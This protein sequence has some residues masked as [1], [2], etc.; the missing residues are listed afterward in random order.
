MESRTASSSAVV[1][2]PGAAEVVWAW[3]GTVSNALTAKASHEMLEMH[4]EPEINITVLGHNSNTAG[5][6]YDYESADAC[7][8]DGDGY[9]IEGLQVSD[10][11]YP[12]WFESSSK[13]GTQFDH[14]QLIKKPFEL[15]PGGYIGHFDVG[16]GSGWQQLTARHS[17]PS[18][19]ARA[20]GGGR[21]EAARTPTGGRAWG[22]AAQALR[23]GLG[24]WRWRPR[25]V[26]GVK[27]AVRRRGS[28]PEPGPHGGEPR[29]P[30]T[31]AWM[32]LAKLESSAPNATATIFALGVVGEVCTVTPW[33]DGPWEDITRNGRAT[34]LAPRDL[35]RSP[36]RICVASDPL[37]AP[38]VLGALL[39]G[40]VTDLVIDDQTAAAVLARM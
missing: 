32:M 1:L 34:G 9:S 10:L 21:R 22:H 33:G 25:R 35:R 39:L 15:R 40:V 8:A 14:R 29:K 3:V 28:L 30:V 7:E 37:R 20:A 17:Q 18:Y 13:K 23:S 27:F 11:V 5:R 12:A 38:A 36:K 24:T 26:G 4:A 19:A 31:N 2:M 6:L 16:S